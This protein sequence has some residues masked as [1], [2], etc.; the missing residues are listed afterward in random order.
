MVSKQTKEATSNISAANEEFITNRSKSYLKDSKCFIPSNA[1]TICERIKVASD[2]LSEVKVSY[3]KKFSFV[4]LCISLLNF[5]GK[6]FSGCR[7]R[8]HGVCWDDFS[9][10][11]YAAGS[12]TFN[13]FASL[14]QVVQQLVQLKSIHVY[15][16]KFNSL[17]E[18]SN[19]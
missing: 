14:E 7:S 13:C 8:I 3:R 16:D 2:A 15:F 6:N 18:D 4:Q 11:I 9:R 5:I 1:V 19:L 17:D 12:L 10:G